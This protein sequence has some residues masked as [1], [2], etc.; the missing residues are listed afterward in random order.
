[1]HVCHQTHGCQRAKSNTVQVEVWWGWHDHRDFLPVYLVILCSLFLFSFRPYLSYL[2]V[3][4]SQI[5]V[6]ALN[7]Q[8]SV[9]MV[10]FP[11]IEFRSWGLATSTSTLEVI[12]LVFLS[13]SLTGSHV[14][15]SGLKLA[16][17]L[18]MPLNFWLLCLYL[19]VLGYWDD[20]PE[21]PQCGLC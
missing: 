4:E 1:M 14:A 8:F 20:R 13:L 9:S 11:R 16:A 5:V 17:N 3:Y 15:Q 18:R 12:L 19:L 10:W 6:T 21:L 7:N 2:H